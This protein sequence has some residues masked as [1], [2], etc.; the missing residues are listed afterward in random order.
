MVC[1]KRLCSADW[2]VRARHLLPKLR[3]I[4]ALTIKTMVRMKRMPGY[5]GDANPARL[6]GG[7]WRRS[8]LLLCVCSSLCF[9]FLLPVIQIS[10]ICLC[11][12]GDP[13]GIQV[14]VVNNETST[15]GYSR[16][17]LSFLDNSSVHQVRITAS[18]AF[19]LSLIL[20]MNEMV[21][22]QI[23]L[24]HVH[25]SDCIRGRGSHLPRCYI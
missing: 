8:H 24:T 11:V 13:R 19:I 1:N 22:E 10:L 20:F 2:K 25:T 17:L 16:S 4:A 3:N 7:A 21:A 12:G 6:R 15:N 14:A 23:G 5:V 18:P 9:Q